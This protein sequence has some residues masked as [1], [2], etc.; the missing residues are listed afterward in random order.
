MAEPYIGEIKMFGGNFAPRSYAL[1]NGQLLAIAQNTALFSI[2]G[3][4]YGGNGKTTFGLPNLQGRAA[5]HWGQGP[6]LT[7]RFIG[8]TGGQTTETL[9]TGQIPAH[10]HLVG[11]NDSNGDSASPTNVSTFGSVGGRGRPP[12]YAIQGTAVPMSPVAIGVSGGGQP[13]NNMQPY[14]AVNFIIALQG[15]FPPR[16]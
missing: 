1:C 13:H 3:T 4:I 10:N 8:E 5:M 11:C 14:L 6:G 12:F 9:T 16:P 15:V 7:D 2:L